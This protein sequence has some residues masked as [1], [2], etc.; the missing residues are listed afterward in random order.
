MARCYNT[1]SKSVSLTTHHFDFFFTSSQ[2]K[3]QDLPDEV[4]TPIL[5]YKNNSFNATL[6]FTLCQNNLLLTPVY[7]DYLAQMCNF[8]HHQHYPTRK[9]IQNYAK[10][11]PITLFH[12][13]VEFMVLPNI[14]QSSVPLSPTIHHLLVFAFDFGSPS[15]KDAMLKALPM[16]SSIAY[17]LEE[18]PDTLGIICD[19]LSQHKSP[20]IDYYDF[21]VELNQQIL[22]APGPQ[23]LILLDSMISFL[24]KHPSKQMVASFSATFLLV[25]LYTNSSLDKNTLSFYAHKITPPRLFSQSIGQILYLLAISS[26]PNTSSNSDSLFTDFVAFINKH[27]TSEYFDSTSYA[28]LTTQYAISHGRTDVLQFLHDH[29][30]ATPTKSDLQLIMR[31]NKS[32][33]YPKGFFTKMGISPQELATN[34]LQSSSGHHASVFSYLDH[35]LQMLNLLPDAN[36]TYMDSAYSELILK[37]GPTFSEYNRLDPQG[38]YSDSFLKIIDTLL[39][40]GARCSNLPSFFPTV[41]SLYLNKT[42]DRPSPITT[43]RLSKLLSAC[44]SNLLLNSSAWLA[45]SPFASGA[46]YR[47]TILSNLS[48]LHKL[49]PALLKKHAFAIRHMLLWKHLS[50]FSYLY[51]CLSSQY[52]AEKLCS[53]SQQHGLHAS[54]LRLLASSSQAYYLPQIDLFAQHEAPPASTLSKLPVPSASSKNAAYATAGSVAHPQSTLQKNHLP[55]TSTYSF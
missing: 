3:P 15:C 11:H 41:A 2:V 31:N 24:E 29:N 52:A 33:S 47:T 5:A 14:R 48:V 1:K 35:L 49:K 40:K 7:V 54:C 27:Y 9:S 45:F 18:D 46:A 17:F 28:Y 50:C 51:C 8:L 55:S 21:L 10:D 4:V 16:S 43:Q 6:C 39:S 37:L 20:P 19:Y 53:V 30:L 26:P 32:L 34:I 36:N 42:Q 38:D 13:Y 44:L 23:H 22:N 25:T 12:N